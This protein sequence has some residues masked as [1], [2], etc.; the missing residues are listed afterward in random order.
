MTEPTP[1]D[2]A[3]A[4]MEQE[5]ANETARLQFY[6]R[7]AD[8]ELFMMLGE[9]PEGDEI[10]PSVFDTEDGRFVLVF[11]REERLAAFA[12][13]VVPYVALS[14]RGVV[15]ML[16]GQDIGL[17]VNLEVAPSAIL[18]PDAAVSWLHQTLGHAPEQVEAGVEEFLPPAGLPEALLTALDVKLAT[19]A[20]LATNA[21]LVALRYSGGGQGHLLGFVDATDG[22]QEALAKAVSEALTFSGIEVGALDVG[23]FAAEDP[24]AARL[25]RVG[26]RFELPALKTTQRSSPAAPGSDPD[27]P[28]RLV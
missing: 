28:P 15:Q 6:E 9:E 3:H 16:V 27:K 19:A 25:A 8:C 18:I 22:A 4:A 26:L 10:S 11:D 24:A 20:G 23:F 13:R 2:L 12:G 7:L 5:P 1:L 14:G 21:Y 17:G